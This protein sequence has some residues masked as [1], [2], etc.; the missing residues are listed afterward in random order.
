M[1]ERPKILVTQRVPDVAYPPLEAIG[2]VEA[3]MEEGLIWPYE[4]LLR[5]GPGHDYIFCLLTDQ[6][7]ARFLEACASA[8]PRLKMV[9]NMAVGYNN[10]DVEA[11][12]RLGIAVSN[13]PGVLSDTTADLAF[14]LLIAVARRI[15]E[16]ERF[17]RAGKF[18]GWGPL[19]FCGVDVHHATLGLI[20]AGRIGKIVA[21]R[22]SGFEMRVLY[23]DV[24]RLPPEEEATYH[25]TYA[26]LDELLRES[27]FVSIHTPYLPSTHHLIGERELSL[28]KPTAYLIN[29][30]RGPVV[31]E[32][33]LVR[34]LQAKQIAGAGLDVYEHEPAIEPE[35]LTMDNVVLLP[36]I[37]SASYATRNQMALMASNNIVAYH[38]G[39]RPPN[40]VNPEV[41]G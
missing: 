40:L 4:E 27:D 8:T 7:D 16:A 32:K 38:E 3:N 39:R 25:L 2:E 20:G 21:K 5:R 28:M 11:A 41:L 17:V 33:A 23:Y 36:H 18:K 30:S 14:G 15:P 6:I 34:A 13:T 37:A 24:Y 1:A 22:A 12:T 26:P 10:I 31:D 9:A 19:L 35:L 29:T